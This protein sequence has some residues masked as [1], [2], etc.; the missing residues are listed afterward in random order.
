M[1][2]ERQNTIEVATANLLVSERS[3]SSA[4][5]VQTSQITNTSEH[6]RDDLSSEAPSRN[7][8]NLQ[9]EENAIQQ[10]QQSARSSTGSAPSVKNPQSNMIRRGVAM[11]FLAQQPTHRQK[12]ETRKK[13]NHTDTSKDTDQHGR[14]NDHDEEEEAD[15]EEPLYGY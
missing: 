9:I 8:D 15:E 10:Q 5:K 14:H 1:K 2:E 6:H 11:S 4:S 3:N 7:Q 12:T 13:Y